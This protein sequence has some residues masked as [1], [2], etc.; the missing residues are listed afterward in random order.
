MRLATKNKEEDEQMEEEDNS[1][2]ERQT[3]KKRKA[4]HKTI[5]ES[6]QSEEAPEN[7]GKAYKK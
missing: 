3:A 4:V 5:S 2:A 6:G 7:L 1:E